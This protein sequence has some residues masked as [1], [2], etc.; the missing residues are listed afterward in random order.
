MALYP[1]Y[2][3]VPYS[4]PRILEPVHKTLVSNFNDM[5]VE[6]RK[7]KWLFHKWN[8]TL[9]YTALSKANARTLWQFFIARDGMY[10]GFHWIDGFVDSYVGEYFGTGD[11]STVTFDLPFATDTTH[12]IYVAGVEKTETTDYTINADAGTDGGDSITFNSAPT[13]GARLTCDF[14]GYLKIRCR[15]DNDAYSFEQFYNLITNVGV[16]LI[17]L[18]LDDT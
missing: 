7:R 2:S 15:F 8:V 16:K 6:Q 11:G 4:N 13:K 17:G 12:V 9:K 1:S 10:G 5:G 14:T 3:E 18:H